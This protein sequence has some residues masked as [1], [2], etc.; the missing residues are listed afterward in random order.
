MNEIS[1]LNNEITVTNIK[2]GKNI[3]N[4]FVQNPGDFIFSKKVIIVVFYCFDV[5]R[6]L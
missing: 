2:K 5:Y 6:D 4:T 1:N 3:L